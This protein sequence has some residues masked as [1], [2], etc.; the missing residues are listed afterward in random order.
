MKLLPLFVIMG[1]VTAGTILLI[2]LGFLLYYTRFLWFFLFKLILFPYYF[3][4]GYRNY[5]EKKRR[6]LCQKL[7]AEY[8][9]ILGQQ[10][11]TLR[12]FEQL[13]DEGIQP[14]ELKRILEANLIHSKILEKEKELQSL[15]ARY[16][17]EANIA[18]FKA[19][20]E[21]LLA[22]TQVTLEQLRYKEK[23]LTQVYD[24]IKE[25]HKAEISLPQESADE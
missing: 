16:R 8:W 12:Y 21:A 22:Q 24:K 2:I 11:N 20:R 17:N 7:C 18:E 13:I 23:L 1:Y 25:K 3:L 19:E 6:R 9:F 5:K 15:D 14:K 4:K 10:P